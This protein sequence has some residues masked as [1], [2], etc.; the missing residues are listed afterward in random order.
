LRRE[1]VEEAV[2]KISSLVK[3]NYVFEE[4]GN[5]IANHLVQEHK[6]GKFSSVKSWAEFASLCTQ[7]LQDYSN[8]GHLYVRYDAKTVK[9]LL[10][11]TDQV[12]GPGMEDPFFHSHEAR[13]RNFGFKEVKVLE[14]NIGYVRL[15][16]IN[17]SEKSLPTMFAAV[18]FVA[19]TRALILDLRDN[20][21][22]GSEVGPVLESIF[23]PKNIT[24]LEYKSRAG[25]VRAEKTVNWLTQEKYGNPLFI[26]INKNT[27]SAAEALTFALQANKRAVVVGQPSAGAAHMNSWYVVN[28]DVFVSIST[29]APT[30][31]GTET[32]WEGKGIQP[33]YRVAGGDEID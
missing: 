23:L 24:L 20:G 19:N 17:I 22:G 16:E 5:R 25:Q 32:S 15:A 9:E 2:M 7:L 28:D 12:A 18:E 26:I 10:T 4:R 6:E 14:G 3:S 11:A 33:D 13:E 29:G 27:A 8:D 1:K 31:P 30:L 21:G